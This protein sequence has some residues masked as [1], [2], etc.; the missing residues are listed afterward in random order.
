MNTFPLTPCPRVGSKQTTILP[1]IKSESEGNYT[2]VRKIATRDR[3][4]FELKYT[5]ITH[6]EFAILES[7]FLANQGMMFEFT[8][9]ATDEVYTCIFTQSELPCN[10]KTPIHIDTDIILEEV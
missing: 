8:N 6:G 3:K 1:I 2:K 7:F 10:Y 5:T 9:Q 4:K